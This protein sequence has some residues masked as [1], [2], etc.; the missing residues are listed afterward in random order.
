VT[1]TVWPAI[2]APDECATV[3]R[4]DEECNEEKRFIYIPIVYI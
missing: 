3:T 1:A 4:T 2:V